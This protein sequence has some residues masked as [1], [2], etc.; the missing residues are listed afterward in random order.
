MRE[1]AATERERERMG[2]EEGLEERPRTTT[3]TSRNAIRLSLSLSLSLFLLWVTSYGQSAVSMHSF[4]CTSAFVGLSYR[5]K[6]RE[7]MRERESG[8]ASAFAV[9]RCFLSV[10]ER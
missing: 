9:F 8:L 4:H 2:G 10:R 7:R 6:D 1:E 3:T 5:K